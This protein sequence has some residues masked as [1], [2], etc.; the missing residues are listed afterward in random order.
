MNVDYS[1]SQY[2]DLKGVEFKKTG[3]ELV[4]RCLFADCDNDSRGNERHLYFS[5]ANTQY[6][7]VSLQEV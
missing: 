2:L 5:E 7:A 3:G 6:H 4:T 1:I